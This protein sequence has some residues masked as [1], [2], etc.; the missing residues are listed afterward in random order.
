M[1]RI[2]TIKPD[3]F[4]NEQLSEL[5]A[6]AR[7]LFVG[8]WTQADREGRMLDRPKRLKAEIFPY[9][10]VDL[11][12]ELS[13][14][15]NAGFIKRYEVGDLKV[16]QID[17]FTKHQRI[18]GSEAETKSD[19]PAPPKAAL[20]REEAGGNILENFGNTLEALRTTGK[21][22]NGKEGN[23]RELGALT[24]KIN[25]TKIEIPNPPPV[26]PPPS[27]HNGPPIDDVIRFFRG[28]GGTEEM[29]M[30]F[31]NKWEST[32]WMDGYSKI[33]NWTP[34]AN[35]FIA[36]WHRN[37][38]LKTDGRKANQQDQ[39]PRGAVISGQKDYGKL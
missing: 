21:E 30:A 13:R 36:A 32:G 2:R 24:E 29:A 9:D 19:L 26:A 1:A 27:Q 3:F 17:K 7:L 38:K 15:Q 6:I 34:K 12:K 33:K 31:W 14:L 39:Q 11:E 23:G 28:A 18:T 16:I 4:K 5:P 20:D 8:L 25:D 35:N 22:G 10:N 37:E